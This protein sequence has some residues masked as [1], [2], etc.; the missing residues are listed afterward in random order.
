MERLLQDFRYSVRMLR[1]SPAFTIA[2][3]AALAL[4]IG[5]NTAIF[6]V[7]NTVLLKPLP[8]PDPDRLMVFLNTSPQ[9]SGPGASPTKFNIWRRQTSAF[10]DVVGLSV[11]R[12]Q[13]DR[14][15]TRSRSRRHTS[16]P[17]SSGLF[18]A[19]VIAGRTFAAAEDL[20]N[21]GH[22]VVLSEGFWKRRF[23]GDRGHRR[24]DAV[25]QRRAARSHRR[26]RPVRYGSHPVAD[27]SAGRLAA[28]PDRSQQRDAGPFLPGRRPPQTRGHARRRQRAAAAGRERV[29]R[30][31]SR[32]R[33]AA[34]PASASQPMQDII[35]RNVRSSLWVLL[36]AVT[37]VLLI[38]C[39]NVA[40]LL[41]VR[42]TVR[43]REIAIRAAIGAGRGRII[44]QLLT[45]SVVL[46]MI[47]GALGLVARR[48]S[49]S[50]RCWPSTPATSRASASTVPAS[51]STGECSPSPRSSRSPPASSSAWFR[52]CRRRASISTRRSRRAAARSGAAFRH[53]KARALLVVSEMGLAL[54]LLVGA[55]LF[56]RTFVA[57]RAVNPGFDA[58]QV[59]T[60][61]MSL[62]RRA[63]REDGGGRAADARRRRTPERAARRRGR[64]RRRAACRSQGG[65][66]LPIIIEGR[67][68]DGPSHGGGGF[69]P[70]SPTYFRAFKIPIVRGRAFTDQD[71]GGSGRAWR[72]STRRWRSGSGRTAI[73][74][75]IASRSARGSVRSSETVATPDR[76]H[77]RRR[78]RRRPQ[79][80]SAADHVRAV[81]ADAGR[82]Q[83]QPARTSRPLAWIV[84]TRGESPS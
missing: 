81:G 65:F 61:R 22:V 10:Q 80:R 58:H 55:A 29:P 66:G 6:S 82:A 21:G 23:G 83:R 72:S 68:L 84:R 31:S 5:A 41:L 28:V 26:A 2:V 74:W 34:R 11:Q 79:P 53:N 36:G 20:P 17:T 45:E 1:R 32:T 76:R 43:K 67:P 50:A 54:V 73:R 75:P 30:T 49:A 77:R 8:Y 63:I 64:R 56:I 59:L 52:R 78:A 71:A 62:T 35:V 47:G 70:I 48:R 4:G 40:N 24:P 46:S 51:A 12:R 14:R 19:P 7:V 39:A 37:F 16:A 38:A 3:V 9:G 60:M 15:A 33:S 25:A 27:W 57:L 18:G 42:A 13:P 69:A 44:R